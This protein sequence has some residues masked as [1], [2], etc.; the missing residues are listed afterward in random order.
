MSQLVRQIPASSY[1]SSHREWVPHL[2]AHVEGVLFEPSERNPIGDSDVVGSPQFATATKTGS[3]LAPDGV[4]HFVHYQENDLEIYHKC[5]GGTAYFCSPDSPVW[6]SIYARAGA[7]GYL[8]VETSS[9]DGTYY[10]VVV[11]YSIVNIT[12]G[13]VALQNPDH[14]IV[15]RPAPDGTGKIKGDSGWLPTWLVMVRW[16]SGPVAVQPSVR[17]FISSGPTEADV[18][19]LG[20]STSGIYLWRTHATRKNYC[21]IPVYT[22]GNNGVGAGAISGDI[23]SIYGCAIGADAPVCGVLTN[24]FARPRPLSVSL[25]VVDRGT[26]FNGPTQG[27]FAIG[28]A[29]GVTGARFGLRGKAGGGLEVFHHNGSTE[30]TST[31]PGTYGFLDHLDIITR[32]NG[33]GSVG[34]TVSINGGSTLTGTTSA[35]NT[36]A[37]SW[38]QRFV[39]LGGISGSSTSTASALIVSPYLRIIAQ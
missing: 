35:S 12:T 15:T 10:G 38:G 39:W 1:R 7:R 37:S 28:H 24:D 8:A 18:N 3:P 6:T 4:D 27:L 34:C 14:L 9:D 30:V 32:L 17:W 23:S 25:Q 20:D 2:D 36:R 13:E 33:D 5:C 26:W 16:D 19:Y 29:D 21:A 11:G 22:V 31:V